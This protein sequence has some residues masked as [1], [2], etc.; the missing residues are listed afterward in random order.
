MRGTSGLRGG[1]AGTG[2]G[3]GAYWRWRGV[4]T[5]GRGGDTV[6]GFSNPGRGLGDIVK[7]QLL[8]K[9][10]M[11]RVREIWLEYHEGHARAVG[12][13]MSGE[14]YGV[15]RQR[16]ERCRHFVVPVMREGGYFVVMVE[17]QG[18]YCF[19]TYLED[20]RR[21][22]GKAQP[23]LTMTMYEEVL[24]TKGIVLVR[25]EVTNH[26]K[27][28]EAKVLWELVRRFYLGERRL[29]DMVVAFNEDGE[30]FDFEEV[31]REARKV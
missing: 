1:A 22:V 25:G 7:M 5:A 18:R 12:D 4:C 19:M 9:Q 13:V 2:G 15:W 16:T 10:G 6:G 21:D 30:R 29:Y 26:L 20:Y 23:Y 3:A 31:V 27:R 24:E 14:E 8:N 17:F 28:D 11:G